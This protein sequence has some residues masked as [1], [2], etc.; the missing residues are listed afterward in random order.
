MFFLTEQEKRAVIFL[1]IIC[2]L[3]I[4]VDLFRKINLLPQRIEMFTK[5]IGKFNL[6]QAGKDELCE[7]PGIG[8]KLAERIISYRRENG[9]FKDIE[10]LMNIK[11]ITRFR[12]DR[13]KDS[14]I[15]R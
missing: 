9:S 13:L 12:F 15:I 7:V 8:E 2:L 11:G 5:N 1:I 4:G 10:Q 6:N 14:L 3:S